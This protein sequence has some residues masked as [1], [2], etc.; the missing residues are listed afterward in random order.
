MIP[1]QRLVEPLDELLGHLVGAAVDLPG[2]RHRLGV[3]EDL[4]EEPD[5]VGR[6]AELEHLPAEGDGVV[7]P[8]VA[9]IGRLLP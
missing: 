7:D 3:A 5:G 6:V 2:P 9:G 4:L 8:L 1:L